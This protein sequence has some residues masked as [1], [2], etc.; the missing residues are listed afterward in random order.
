M[1]ILKSLQTECCN[2]L[3]SPLHD[4]RDD[5]SIL[6]VILKIQPFKKLLDIL[7]QAFNNLFKTFVVLLTDAFSE[8]WISVNKNFQC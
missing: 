5:L 3:N 7:Q 4:S 6:N 1:H 8:N 2:K